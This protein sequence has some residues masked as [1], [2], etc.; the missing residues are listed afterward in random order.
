MYIN[1]SLLRGFKVP[2][3]LK[4]DGIHQIFFCYQ[5][6]LISQ[7]LANP[8]MFV[9]WDAPPHPVPVASE[10]LHGSPY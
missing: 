9:L 10:A 5:G 2:P 4:N 8:W 7:T 6:T 3:G 1:L